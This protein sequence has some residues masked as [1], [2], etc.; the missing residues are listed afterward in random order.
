M[1]RSVIRRAVFVWLILVAVLAGCTAAPR[2]RQPGQGSGSLH[3]TAMIPHGSMVAFSE[4]DYEF[5][6]TLSQDNQVRTVTRPLGQ[7]EL[8]FSI[9]NL[10]AGIWEATLQLKDSEG[11]ITHAASG[12]V[13]ILPDEIATVQ[14]HLKPEPGELQVTIDLS[15][16]EDPILRAKIQSARVYVSPGGYSTGHLDPETETIVIKRELQ[17]QSYDFQVILYSD[18]F[19]AANREYSSPWTPVD[20]FPG[21]TT[22]IV[23]TPSVG[24]LDLRGTVLDAPAPPTELQGEYLGNGTVRLTW[25]PPSFP[26]DAETTGIRIYQRDGIFGAYSLVDEVSADITSWEVPVSAKQQSFAFAVTAFAMYTIAPDTVFESPR[27]SVFEL[28]IP[29]QP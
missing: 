15:S 1:N 6:L 24:E 14:F 7:G 23:W 26:L 29:A 2:L 27:S 3:V 10:F 28:T 13:I 8:T 18:G 21:K 19:L 22:A 5:E 20:I 4:Q 16:I 9:D 11:D 17:P 12:E 25:V